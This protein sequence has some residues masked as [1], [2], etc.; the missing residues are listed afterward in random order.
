[1][2]AEEEESVRQ[3]RV[4]VLGA[5]NVGSAVALGW[6]RA[7]LFQP[8]E[9]V[10]IRRNLDA[11]DPRLKFTQSCQA[12]SANDA[13]V[14]FAALP[15][16][17]LKPVL[18]ELDL[19]RDQVLLSCVAGVSR[20]EL[21]RVTCATVGRAMPNVAAAVNQSMTCIAADG[22]ALSEAERL[23]APLGRVERIAEPLMDSATVLCACGLAFF[24]RSVRS[25][26]QG[27]VEIGFHADEA[28]RLAA[29]TALGACSLLLEPDG[30]AH[31]E[32]GIDRVTTP[33]GCTI[34]GLNQLEHGG[35]SSA[36]IKA[37]VHSKR[38]LDA[39]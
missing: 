26:S 34:V 23:F 30:V 22:D 13:D 19:T 31:P 9:V 32:Q 5:G 38:R 18:Q 2:Q 6:Q 4:A 1:M 12:S 27:G 16:A 39:T 10:L 7:G 14:V 8:N 35:F 20:H 28:Q 15:V 3:F 29:Q 25:A 17:A 24:L 33:N 11:L 36:F 21:L 37:I